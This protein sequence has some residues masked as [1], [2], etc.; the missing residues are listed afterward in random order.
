[1]KR[2]PLIALAL[3]SF[4]ILPLANAQEA[5]P[6]STPSSIAGTVI[7]EPGSQPVK[8]VLVQV[9]AED[10]KHGGNYSTSTDADGRFHIENAVPGRYRIFFEK[11]GFIEVNGRGMKADVN[12]LTIESGQALQ[13]LLFRMLPGAVISGR[14]TDEDGDPMSG[15]RERSP[16]R[17]GGKRSQPRRRTILANTASPVYFL[18]S[19]G[20]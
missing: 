5:A 14:I 4:G 16:G 8:K 9:V 15:I 3:C 13:D 12:V 2:S 11:T 6:A 1:M 10:Q 20:W 18:A 19:I 17:R 7:Q